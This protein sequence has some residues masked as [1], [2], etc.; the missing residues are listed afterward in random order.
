MAHVELYVKGVE[1]NTRLI[2][3][4]VLEGAFDL[5][6]V[7]EVD[8]IGSKVLLLACELRVLPESAVA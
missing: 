8:Q 3:V 6:N 1:V 2:L 7:V 4:D 5:A